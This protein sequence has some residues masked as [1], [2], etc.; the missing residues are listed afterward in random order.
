MYIF[1]TAELE[2]KFRYYELSKI[3]SYT[4]CPTSNQWN[5]KQKS[6]A[7]IAQLHPHPTLQ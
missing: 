2:K 1:E 4:E 5:M 7:K 3:V 6:N